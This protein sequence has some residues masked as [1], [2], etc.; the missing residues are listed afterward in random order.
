MNRAPVAS[1]TLSSASYS[2]DSRIL[3]REFCSGTIYRYFDIPQ[4]IHYALLAAESKGKF[5]NANIRNC[6]R[7]QEISHPSHVPVPDGCKF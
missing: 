2:R 4:E 3:E 6:F 5:F 7:Y 1:S